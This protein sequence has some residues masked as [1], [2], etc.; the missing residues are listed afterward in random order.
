M[1]GTPGRADASLP[2]LLMLGFYAFLAG[3]LPVFA[4]PFVARDLGL[5][6]AG[7]T[8]LMGVISLG[9]LGTFALTRLADRRGRRTALLASFAS[10]APL[11]LFSAL[12]PGAALYALF[13]MAATACHGTLRTVV[14]VAISEVA[15]ERSRAR[16]QAWFGLVSSLGG[17][18][19]L[20]LVSGLGNSVG[21]WRV[22]FGVGA[23][24]LVAWPWVHRGIAETR[25]FDH[26]RSQG[27]TQRARA[28]DLFTSAYRRRA[29][30][31]LAAGTLRGIGLSALGVWTYYHAI[32]GLGLEP[33]AVTAVYVG[34]GSL[35]MLGI[36]AGAILSERWGRRPTLLLGLGITVAAGLLYFRVPGQ[37]GNTTLAALA[38][39]FFGYNFGFQCFGVADRL[40]DTELFPTHLR[41]TYA[42]LRTIGEALSQM[43]AHFSL[44]GLILP[45]GSLPAA[46][47]ALVLA[48]AAPSAAIFLWA[49]A[50]TRGLRLEIASLE[51]EPTAPEAPLATSA[52]AQRP[53]LP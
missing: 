27:R 8:F 4:A 15:Q 11:S 6:D 14:T 21:G 48:T 33:W 39:A 40:L 38:L 13:Q 9:A 20:V 29:A 37:Q 23:A 35:A 44:A 22:G 12:S 30:G 16:G 2:A 49:A 41:A 53:P 31:L 10:L 52:E 45:L 47:S 51:E 28:R 32:H 18:V 19:P 1:D 46:I 7:I 5:G 36:P 50:E 25:R 43:T 3:S 17:A 24:F 26:A 34:G 42:G